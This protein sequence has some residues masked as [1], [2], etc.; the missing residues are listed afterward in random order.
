MPTDASRLP[1]PLVALADAIEIVTARTRYA[2]GYQAYGYPEAPWHPIV[3]GQPP[4][5]GIHRASFI[6][7]IL[8]V[9][10]DLRHPSVSAELRERLMRAHPEQVGGDQAFYE[11]AV[12]ERASQRANRDHAIASLALK[13]ESA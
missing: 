8:C 5:D 11:Y 7:R 9:R 2:T 1:A 12:D 13:V 10:L 6:S 4:H 3:E